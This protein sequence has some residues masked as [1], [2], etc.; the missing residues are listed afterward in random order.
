MP[1]SR[2][3]LLSLLVALGCITGNCSAR[4]VNA[5]GFSF[6]APRGWQVQHTDDCYLLSSPQKS[7]ME[8]YTLSVCARH[9]PLE[10]VAVDELF[11]GQ[12]DGQ[13]MRYAGISPPSPVDEIRG[14][15]WTGLRVIQTCGVGDPESGFHAAGGDCLMAVVSNGTTSV[16]FDSVG[17]TREFAKLY[18]IIDSVR[19][20][21]GD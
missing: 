21:S 14:A 18:A 6:K 11:F 13:W 16:M 5:E 2:N 9:A 19:F 8:E 20:S 12:E 7:R 17:L 3:A 10:Q 15:G 1:P 4:E